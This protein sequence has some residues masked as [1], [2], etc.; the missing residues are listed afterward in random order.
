[1]T[2]DYKRHGTT[3][4]FA[5]LNTLD[6]HV[7][8]QCRDRH[9]HGDWIA[10]LRLIHRHSPKNKQIHI[11]AYNYAACQRAALARES[12]AFPRTLH[13]DQRILVNMVERFFRDIT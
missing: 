5:A 3:T 1:M 2:H 4:L 11:I 13:A 8:S 7:L 12:Q 6:G 10:I 9:T